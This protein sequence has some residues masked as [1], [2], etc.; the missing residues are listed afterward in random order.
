M[1]SMTTK[2]PTEFNSQIVDALFAHALSLSPYR[3]A[4]SGLGISAGVTKSPTGE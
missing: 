1:N 4:A 3:P 2:K